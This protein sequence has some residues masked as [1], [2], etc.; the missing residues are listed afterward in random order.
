MEALTA[1]S[2][3][4]INL[5]HSLRRQ[6]TG[7]SVDRCTDG[8]V[9]G[10]KGN[11]PL[12]LRDILLESKTGGKSGEYRHQQSEAGEIVRNIT[13]PAQCVSS[14]SRASQAVASASVFLPSPT[15]RH[16]VDNVNKKGD[17]VGVARLAGA[18]AADQTKALVPM[19][20]MGMQHMKVRTYHHPSGTSML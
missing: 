1:V 15:W 12:R 6:Q 9:F 13:R 16:L 8:S 18:M 11:N 7:R 4:A 17:V 14:D 2:F 10:P 19:H 20:N 5:L 3:A